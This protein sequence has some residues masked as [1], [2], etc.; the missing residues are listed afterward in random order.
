MQYHEFIGQVQNRARLAAQDDAVKATRSTLE[1]LGER[2][3]GNEAEHIASQLPG[4][5][6]LFLR[7]NLNKEKYSVDEFFKRVSEKEG[8]ELPE[9]VFHTRVVLD[10]LKEAVSKGGIDHIRS[11]LPSEYNRLF[12]SENQ[13]N[14][15][16]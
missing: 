16:S 6:G 1:T 4:E 7:Y 5:I 12:E 2:L 14:Y 9:A 15:R 11:Q 10:V 3:F 8:V 13:A